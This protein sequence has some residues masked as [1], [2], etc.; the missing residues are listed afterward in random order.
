[1]WCENMN[2]FLNDMGLYKVVDGKQTSL[3]DEFDFT[4]DFERLLYYDEYRTLYAG[5]DYL[6]KKKK[7]E[8]KFFI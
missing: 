3:T 1:M 7:A 4:I 6:D 8:D 2:I 5:S